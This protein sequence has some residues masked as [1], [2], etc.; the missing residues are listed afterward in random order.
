MIN[1][2]GSEDMTLAEVDAAACLIQEAA[3][4]DANI[5]FGAVFNPDLDGVALRDLRLPL[6][7]LVLAVERAGA[8]LISHGYTTLSLGDRV[9]VVGSAESLIEVERKF[10]ST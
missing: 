4:E 1:V 9:T 5:I 8:T 2:T 6:D 7:T 10:Q 3:D